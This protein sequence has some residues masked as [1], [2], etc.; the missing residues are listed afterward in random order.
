MGWRVIITDSEGLTGVGPDCP[1][2]AEP[3]GPH[4]FDPDDPDET[5]RFDDHGVY[6]CCPKPHIE[7]YATNAAYRVVGTLNDCEAEVCT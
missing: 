5:A 2:T 1:R 6:D 3:G 7:C 4:D